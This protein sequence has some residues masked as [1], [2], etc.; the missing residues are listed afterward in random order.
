MK[1]IINIRCELL[2][3][4]KTISKQGERMQKRSGQLMHLLKPKIAMIYRLYGGI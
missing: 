4:G 3:A 1:N 2:R